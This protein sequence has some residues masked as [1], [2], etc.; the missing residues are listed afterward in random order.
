MFV[1]V[2]KLFWMV[3]LDF[4]TLLEAETISLN[5]L[6]I[7]NRLDIHICMN[8]NLHPWKLVD[9]MNSVADIE[10][11][12]SLYSESANFRILPNTI[13][14]FMETVQNGTTFQINL[15]SMKHCITTEMFRVKVPYHFVLVPESSLNGL[16]LQ[17]VAMKV[18][19]EFAHVLDSN[20]N[21]FV[22]PDSFVAVGDCVEV[23]QMKTSTAIGTTRFESAIQDISLRRMDMRQVLI[24]GIFSN[25]T[26]RFLPRAKPEDPLQF[27]SNNY[28]VRIFQY[29][30]DSLNF[31]GT[32]VLGFEVGK[33]DP[34][35]KMFTNSGM[36]ASINHGMADMS[37]SQ[38]DFVPV[39][40]N[41]S[42]GIRYLH[43][44]ISRRSVQLL[45]VSISDTG[46][47]VLVSSIFSK[48]IVFVSLRNAIAI[49]RQPS[50]KGAVFTYT[51]V[52]SVSVWL[53]CFMVM[54]AIFILIYKNFKAFSKMSSSHIFDNSI[55]ITFGIVT[56]RGDQRRFELSTFSLRLLIF[57]SIMIC[58]MFHCIYNSKLTSISTFDDDPIKTLQD[59][60]HAGFDFI[61][62]RV[63]PGLGYLVSE[64]LNY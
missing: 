15:H 46:D 50:N 53:S 37:V 42:T 16:V 49:F 62:N 63:T 3:L 30:Q 8:F 17:A 35:L 39:R 44:T 26:K 22:C 2:S 55:S 27:N 40:M 13:L 4:R 48:I 57:T 20:Q 10:T 34:I 58:F 47:H 45:H 36:V 61:V 64:V 21:I 12:C 60:F 25:K 31:I 33:I 41:G 38:Y 1:K 43:A 11:C 7:F 5:H 32:P 9:V 18:K 52:F 59:L 19:A 23:F 56:L 6:P 24:P 54:I 28:L 51:R 14:W 29:L